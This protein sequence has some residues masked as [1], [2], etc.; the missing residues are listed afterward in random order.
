LNR[1]LGRAQRRAS[2]PRGY[3]RETGI[4]DAGQCPG[5]STGGTESSRPDALTAELVVARGGDGRASVPRVIVGRPYSPATGGTKPAG[6]EQRHGGTPG[7]APV[8]DPVESPVLGPALTPASADVTAAGRV[9]GRVP[10]R[11]LPP[12]S[13]PV[14][15]RV[16]PPWRRNHRTSDGQAALAPLSTN[17][18][19]HG[20]MRP[21]AIHSRYPDVP[22][23]TR[24]SSVNVAREP[25]HRRRK[26]SAPNRR[27]T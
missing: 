22:A 15:N 24:S 17:S 26:S 19:N 10:S 23:I 9:I 3:G 27:R 14:T 5:D 13:P 7:S 20:S 25:G 21:R 6:N 11:V 2:C 8:D 16:A 12:V 18:A 4:P 1:R